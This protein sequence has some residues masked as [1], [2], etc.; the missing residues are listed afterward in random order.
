MP[1]DPERIAT[2]EAESAHIRTTLDE[3]REDVK[4]IKS[5]LSRQRGF[6]A[7]VLFILVPIWSG[8][9]V[10]GKALWDRFAEFGS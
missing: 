6:I 7:G 5:S 10:A 9:L 8:I 3:V 1:T 4:M 2:L